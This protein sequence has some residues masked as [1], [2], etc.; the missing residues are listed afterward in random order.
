MDPSEGAG[1]RSIVLQ[2]LSEAEAAVD[3]LE[4]RRNLHTLWSVL[5]VSPALIVPVVLGWDWDGVGVLSVL[6][7]SALMTGYEALKAY[8]A[9]RQLPELRRIAEERRAELEDASD[10]S[11]VSR[12]A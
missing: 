7:A 6:A 1:E 4:A 11:E 9:N 8:R 12:E 10:V 3:R 5:G 2:E